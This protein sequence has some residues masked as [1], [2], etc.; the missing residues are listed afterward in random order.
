MKLESLSY[1]RCPYTGSAYSTAGDPGAVGSEIEFGVVDSEAGS[2]PVV[3]GVLRLLLDDL[4]E[5]LVQLVG[6][7]RNEDALKAAL[8]V[9]F[10]SRRENVTNALWRRVARRVSKDAG[11][12]AAGPGKRRVYELATQEG[13]F[14]DVVSRVATPNW[15]NWQALR[16]TMPTFLPVFPLAHVA[17]GRRTIFDFGCGLGHSAFLLQRV[18]PDSDLVCGDYSFTSMYLAKRFLAPQ[19]LCICLDGDYPLPF[20]NGHFDCVFSTDALQYIGPKVGLAREFGRVLAPDGTIALAHL[21]NRLSPERGCTGTALTPSGYLGL[22]DGMERRLY[23]ESTIVADYVS[24]GAL[25][26]ATQHDLE[27]GA[28]WLEG[29]SL[30]ASRSASVFEDLGG[31][32]DAEVDLMRRPRLN[33]LYTATVDR[34]VLTAERALGEPFARERSVSGTTILPK[35]AHLDVQGL[36]CASWLSLRSSNRAAFRE[37]VRQFLVLDFPDGYLPPAMAAA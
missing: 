30:V 29:V 22:F 10:L 36:D 18:A 6:S 7:G 16:F 20:V 23:P 35:T 19:S 15:A 27:G 31:L 33:P 3:G 2:F 37:L 13:A 4:R 25:K 9:P 5:P 11:V 26:L 32:V 28:P 24:E 14:A 34:G 1:L 12:Y 17:R 21:H 8:E